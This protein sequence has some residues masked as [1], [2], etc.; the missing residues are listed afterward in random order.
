MRGTRITAALAVC[1]LLA[2][3]GLAQEGINA[4]LSGTVSDNTGALVPGVE[5]TA[6]NLATGVASTTITNETGTFRFPSLQPGEYQA[7]AALGGFQT[8]TF[9][10]TLGTSQQIRQNF[11]LQVGNV[12][13]AVEVT[14]AADALLTASTAS[15]G[16]V[17]PANQ[18]VDLPLVGHNVMDL[19]TSTMPGVTGN[20]QASTTFGGVTADASANVGI[21]LD[22]VTM[23]TGRHTQGLKPTFF[24]TPDLVDEMRVVVAPVDVEG[25]GA[26]QIQVRA[27]SGGNQFHGAVT[28]NIRNSALNAAAWNDNRLGNAPIWYNRHQTTESLGGPILKNKTFFFALYD[29]QDQLQKQ[30][31]DSLVL[32]PLARQG[33]FRF[34]PGVNNGNADTVANGSGATRTVAV[35]DRLGNPL[36]QAQVGATGPMQS[37]NVFG[38]AL[39]PGD[40]FRK[41]MDPTGYIAKI[42]NVMPMP[43]AYN[44]TLGDGL[45]TAV[46]RFTQRTVGVSP[47]GTGQFIDAYNRNQINLKIDHNFSSRHRLSGTWVRE[48]HYSDNNDLSPWPNG[49]R[50]EIR[51]DPRVRTL[52][53]T[54]TLSPN[55]LNEARYAYRTTSLQWTP[56]I[57]TPGVSSAAMGF[58]PQVNGYP[59]YVRPVLFPNTVIGSSAD[60]GNTSPLTTY[61]D[62]MSWTHGAHAFK[63]G[64]EFRY[65]YTSG[66]Q[67]TPVT[68]PTL[69]LIPTVTG[70]AGGVP[71]AGIQ[72]VPN[73]LTNNI[74]VAQNLLLAL[75]G[76][77]GSVSERFET[78]EPTDTQFLDY[79]TSYHHPGQP[80]GTRGKIRENHQ[81]EFNWFFKDDW[82]V[83]SN[84]TL[85]LGLRWDLFR[86]PD[87]RSGTGAFWTRGPVDGIA[88]WFGESGRNFNQAFHNGGQSLGGLTQIALIGKGSK[89][90]DM[91][92]WP[93]DKHNF[94]PAVGFAWSPAFGGKDKTTIRGG[95]QIA[96]LLPGNSLSWIDNDLGRL[97]GIEYSATDSGGSAYRDLT[98][99]SFPLASPSSIPSVVTVPV[100]E[101]STAQ[102]FFAPNYTSPYV[103][104]FT[105]GFTRSLPSN[106]ILDVKYL[107][108]RGV[109]LHS[110]INYNEPDFQ[111]NGLLD[112]L[113]TTRAGGNAPLFDQ[114]LNGLNLGTGIGVVGRDVTGSE[115]LRRHSSFRANIANGNFD[116]VANTLN[117][118]NIG[119]NVPAG[120]TVA[121]ATL[122]SSGL[123]PENF[124]VSNPQFS[125]M[126]MRN[127]SDSS[128][129]HSLQTQITM[130]QKHGITYQA[131]WTWSRATGVTSITPDGGGTTETYRDF[132]NRH[133]DYSV[134][135][136]QQTHNFRGY[137]TLELPFGPGK[138]V[139]GNTHGALARAIEGWQFG[140]IF[141][142]FTGSPLNVVS[143]TT[144]NRT[145]TPDLIGNF[146]RKGQVTW[147]NPFGNFFSQQFYGVPDPSCA[148][149][150]ANLAQFCTNRAL[151]TDPNGQNIILQNAAPG[152]PGTLGLNPIYGPGSWDVDA[153]I[154][155][156][157][158]IGES[159][160]LAF[161]MDTQNVFNHPSP[162]APNL[163]INSGTFGQI[164]T[165]TGNR[166]LAG[167]IRFQ[168]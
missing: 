163:N 87:F 33:I 23:N 2:V 124:I 11:T 110:S 39:N 151:A 6:K 157:I 56:A 40:P 1:L 15:V 22:G 62:D 88:G 43:N 160:N 36:S 13:Q 158:R 99:L 68:T 107:G 153:N 49:Y 85:N 138:F 127:N 60:F 52:N 111:H 119:V 168:F 24:V 69:G 84:L 67:P 130:R 12:A 50:G 61:S 55:L 42:L 9:R 53:F 115:A 143:T 75:A 20:G 30:S 142:A 135:N 101:R 21:S 4:A 17:L 165:K 112:A 37:F 126:E 154:Q 41:Q 70:G 34:F 102:S 148:K 147:G 146:P 137:A 35:V 14:T 51:E 116:A 118:T 149:E 76:S 54:S 32:T 103:Q 140:S 97:P 134:A 105:F 8:Q 18:V 16:T 80:S 92:I 114:M 109:K 71:V 29:R 155:K 94:S 125:T 64:I 74:T 19:V 133:A 90:P 7:S 59:V 136:F 156:R 72:N 63:G 122:R 48:G 120:Q 108:T 47:G 96:K 81:N 82:K 95:Y 152:Q 145:G 57:E 121:G 141:N 3:S 129:Y 26:A 123:F 44:G 78:W 77:V 79:K 117:T 93:S 131:T 162:G 46:V 31:T 25:R 86:V 167:Q 27:R 128:T 100:T 65:A 104:T 91:G 139:G 45:N 113:N 66:Y 166:T 89:Y 58:L 150:P 164:S 132:T 5:V 28:W 159:K 106:L 144:I 83:K 98:S 38:D 161:R 73:L 10:L